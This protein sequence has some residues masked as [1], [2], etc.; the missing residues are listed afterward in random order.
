MKKL[1]LYLLAA[2][3]M[4]L[5][6]APAS[7][8]ALVNQETTYYEYTLY[9]PDTGERLEKWRVGGGYHTE[10]GVWHENEGPYE[11]VDN[12]PDGAEVQIYDALQPVEITGDYDSVIAYGVELTIYGSVNYLTVSYVSPEEGER[13][14]TVNVYGDIGEVDT[15]PEFSTMASVSLTG[16]LRCGYALYNRYTGITSYNSFAW[17]GDGQTLA[18]VVS[19]GQPL[20]PAFPCDEPR[21]DDD[22]GTLESG[23]A[24]AVTLPGAAALAAAAGSEG[25]LSVGMESVTLTAEQKSAL[26]DWWKAHDVSPRILSAVELTIRDT[27]TG[28]AVET[29]AQPASVRFDIPEAF[30]KDGTHFQ[31]YCLTRQDGTIT[32]REMN[33]FANELGGCDTLLSHSGTYVVTR[34]GGADV[35]TVY[36]VGGGAVAALLLGGL[37]A[38][39]AVKKKESQQ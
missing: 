36:Y 34:T 33:D 39:K 19:G 16:S 20:V 9:D 26:S 5:A 1:S 24:V 4:L 23:K 30:R 14:T 21:E 38:V 12:P 22:G 27:V 17:T 31:V 35:K 7:V 15:Y 2:A 25:P 13:A 10:D 29:L 11:Y 18:P 8:L 37:I 32:V 3:L 28:E 6:A